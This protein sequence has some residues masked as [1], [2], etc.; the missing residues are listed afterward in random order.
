MPMATIRKVGGET[1]LYHIHFL[2]GGTHPDHGLPG[3]P[4]HPSH[5]LPGSPGPAISRSRQ[6][7][8]PPS[9][10]QRPANR[11][12]KAARPPRGNHEATAW[13]RRH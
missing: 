6:G 2:D 8:R 4:P 7:P 13:V 3:G 12:K 9:F 10:S 11:I 1:D 5:G